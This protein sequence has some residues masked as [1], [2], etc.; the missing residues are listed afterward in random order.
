VVKT[1]TQVSALKK[2]T[3]GWE[4]TFSDG[5]KMEKREVLVCVGRVPNHASLNLAAAGVE[6]KGRIPVLNDDLQ[7][8][9]PNIYVAGDA[10]TTR[11]AHAAAAQ[12]EVAAAN[13][14][15]E[16]RRYDDRFVPRC[17]YSWPEVASVGAWEG[18]KSRGF[19]K[20]SA[21]ALAANETDGFVQIVS[22][23]G[24]DKILGA[25]IIGAH[26]TELIHIF[27]IALKKEMTVKE[28]SEVM[29]AHPTLSEV[30]KDAAKK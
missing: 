1:N 27:S 18:K 11:L 13:A 22:D 26:A 4:V 3:H 9:N 30:I 6:M 12:G 29:F 17:L 28:L 19:F 14:R 16:S 7:T 5:E 24:T 21:K 8:T 20:G 10:G 15:G 23:P 25:Q 2:L